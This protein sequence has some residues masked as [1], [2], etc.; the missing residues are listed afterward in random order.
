MSATELLRGGRPKYFYKYLDG[1]IEETTWRKASEAIIGRPIPYNFMRLPEYIMHREI[2]RQLGESLDLESVLRAEVAPSEFILYGAYAY[3]RYFD[4]YQWSNV[5]HDQSS[6][7]YLVNQRGPMLCDLNTN[8]DLDAIGAAKYAVLWSHWDEAEFKMAEFLRQAQLRELG[9]VVAE[10]DLSPIHISA[11]K[12]EI[13]AGGLLSV[14][15]AY[16]D[17]WVKKQFAFAIDIDDDN[18]L[19]ADLEAPHTPDDSGV[20]LDVML[21]GEKLAYILEPGNSSISMPL[22]QQSQNRLMFRFSGG[23]SESNGGR[24][25]YARAASCRIVSQQHGENVRSCL[26]EPVSSRA[27]PDSSDAPCHAS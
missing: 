10:P 17:G 3:E 26:H 27:A 16:S 15:G 5:A 21:N 23:V 2:L 7:G 9:G 4:M 14:N 25:L 24:T 8:V 6:L 1:G 13:N 19:E 11:S 20:R 18:L 22:K 12:E